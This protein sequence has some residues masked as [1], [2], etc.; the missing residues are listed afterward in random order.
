MSYP[1]ATMRSA[2]MNWRKQRQTV[3][4]LSVLSDRTLKDIGLHR[5][6]IRSRA[7]DLDRGAAR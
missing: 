6:E 4:E 1:F 2:I 3:A 5:S 7:V